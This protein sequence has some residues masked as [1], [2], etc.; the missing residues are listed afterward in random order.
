MNLNLSNKVALVTGSS[1]GIGKSIAEAL[2]AEGCKLAING[3]NE[4]DL[5]RVSEGMLGSF[6]VAGDMTSFED[7]RAVIDKVIEKFG[8]LDIL[9]CNVGS[10]RSVPPGDETAQEWGRVFAC[11]LFST[12]NAVEAARG[13]LALTKGVII[14]ISSICGLEVIRGAPVTYSAAKAALHAYVR[15]IAYPLGKI[16][17]RINAVAPGNIIFEGSVWDGKLF[18]DFSG[19]QALFSNN[20]AFSRFGLPEEVAGLVVCLASSYTSYVTGAILRVDGGYV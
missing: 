8:R 12:T 4:S 3:R 19:T 16:G 10:G 9:V 2:H 18:T 5:K 6:A 17:V 15:G 11:N 7:A 13:A 1:R 20:I 14:C